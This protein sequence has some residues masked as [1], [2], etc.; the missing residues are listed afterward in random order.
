MCCLCADREVS[1][2]RRS[3][4]K[5]KKKLFLRIAVFVNARGGCVA[6][7]DCKDDRML[8]ECEAEKKRLLFDCE[9]QTQIDILDS[10]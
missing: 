3:E 4:G 7:N 10:C 9:G 2:L 1:K 8:I 5:E 6:L